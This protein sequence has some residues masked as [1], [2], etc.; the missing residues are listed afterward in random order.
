MLDKHGDIIAQV[1]LDVAVKVTDI[2]YR[3]P[4]D[5]QERVSGFNAC[6][7]CR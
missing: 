3:L 7:G 5:A 4:V 2:A 1:K 6:S